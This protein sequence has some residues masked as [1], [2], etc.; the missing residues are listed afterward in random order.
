M[1]YDGVKTALELANGGT[2]DEKIID[3]GVLI[4]DNKNVDDKEVQEV[5]NPSK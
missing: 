2:V 1:G 3:T 5:I 4:V